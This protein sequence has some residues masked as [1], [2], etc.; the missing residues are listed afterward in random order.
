M[1]SVKRSVN[2]FNFFAGTETSGNK[3]LDRK[4]KINGLFRGVSFSFHEGDQIEFSSKEELR[5]EFSEGYQTVGLV[6][7][8]VLVNG[9]PTEV[10]IYTL[11]KTPRGIV[12]LDEERYSLF[13]KNHPLYAEMTL[14][15]KSDLSAFIDADLFGRKFSVVEAE[16]TCSR[17]EGEDYREFQ[18]KIWA[19]E[20]LPNAPEPEQKPAPRGAQEIS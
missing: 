11:R 17:G 18:H 20:E 1:A 16:F 5:A 19:L 9:H 13:R 8:N 7:K 4:A 14:S 15:P 6:L 10:P 12:N 2:L 3:D